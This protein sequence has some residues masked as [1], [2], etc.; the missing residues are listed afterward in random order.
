VSAFGERWERI[1]ELD[2]ELLWRQT[3]LA[4]QRSS[5]DKKGMRESALEILVLRKQIREM[6]RR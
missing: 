2:R 6:A 4:E 5:G 3:E 1:R